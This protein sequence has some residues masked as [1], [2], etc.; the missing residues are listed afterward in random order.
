MLIHYACIVGRNCISIIHFTNNVIQ[1]NCPRRT[2]CSS[3]FPPSIRI[4]LIHK[5]HICYVFHGLK[6][7]QLFYPIVRAYVQPHRPQYIHDRTRPPALRR[8]MH[9]RAHVRVHRDHYYYQFKV[10]WQNFAYATRVLGFA[11]PCICSQISC[12]PT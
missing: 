11:K 2:P 4:Q 6:P 5:P 12:W 9:P 7:L 3:A 8:S 10:G 1:V